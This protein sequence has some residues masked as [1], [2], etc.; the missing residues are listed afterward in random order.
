M[1]ATH[2]TVNERAAATSASLRRSARARLTLVVDSFIARLRYVGVMAWSAGVVR[3]RQTS[4]GAAGPSSIRRNAAVPP[5]PLIVAIVV[6]PIFAACT[7]RDRSASCAAGD[8]A[9]P[10]SSTMY[11]VYRALSI[12]RTRRRD[13]GSQPREDQ[14]RQPVASIA[15]R[16][17]GASHIR[18]RLLDDRLTRKDVQKLRAADAA[19]G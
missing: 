15:L 10:Q 5:I 7:M 9:P 6:R 4:T 19:A 3:S 2:A 1:D 18:A 16:N 17:S 8:A 11:M 14:L 13:F 12:W